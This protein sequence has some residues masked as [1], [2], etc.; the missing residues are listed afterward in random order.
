VLEVGDVASVILALAQK[1]VT[2]PKTFDFPEILH[3]SASEAMTKYDMAIKFG[4]ILGV[5]TSHLVRVDEVDEATQVSRPRDC[6]LDC[7]RLGE[8]GIGVNC[9]KFEAWWR[10]YLRAYR[11]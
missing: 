11:H 5:D 1:W 4:E 9:V 10:R 2:S 7:G 6:R 3:F 8:L